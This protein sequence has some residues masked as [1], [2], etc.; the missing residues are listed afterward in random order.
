MMKQNWFEMQDIR[1]RKLATAVWIPLRA[2]H[3]FQSE[4]EFG[5]VGF[6]KDFYGVGTL[7]VC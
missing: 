1:R 3:N 7:A 2:M 5:Y 4:G 6:V